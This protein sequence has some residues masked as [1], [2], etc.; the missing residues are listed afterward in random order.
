MPATDGVELGRDNLVSSV[1]VSCTLASDGLFSWSWSGPNEAA[2]DVSRTSVLT[3]DATLTSILKIS[4][5]SL[6]DAGQYTCTASMFDGIMI[7]DQEATKSL[8]VEISA[9]GKLSRLVYTALR[10][11]S[12]CC[13]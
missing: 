3:A 7:T 2:L 12:C 13:K 11:I 5:F 6:S 9:E 10:L 8:S 4:N 1:Q